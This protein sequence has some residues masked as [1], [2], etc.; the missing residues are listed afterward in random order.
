M[1]KYTLN[2]IE[3]VI[4]N[5]IILLTGIWIG[6]SYQIGKYQPQLDGLTRQLD[7]TQYQLKKVSEESADK[8]ARIAELTGN[9]G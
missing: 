5:L 3:I 7:R 1:K 9:G 8:T 4:L 2:R 6:S